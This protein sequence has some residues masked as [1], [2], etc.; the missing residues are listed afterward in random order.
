MRLQIEQIQRDTAGRGGGAGPN[1]G[2]RDVL[3][4]EGGSS[5]GGVGGGYAVLHGKRAVVGDKPVMIE[6]T[7]L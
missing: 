1:R 2:S 3:V 4:A 6:Q 7:I 5:D